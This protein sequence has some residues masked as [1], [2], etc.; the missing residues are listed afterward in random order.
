MEKVK[1]LTIN[2]EWQCHN[3]HSLNH[4][5]K[6]TYEKPKKVYC[7]YCNK[8]YLVEGNN[9]MIIKEKIDKIYSMVSVIYGMVFGAIT[10]EIIWFIFRIFKE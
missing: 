6:C 2:L 9:E 7:S 3:C 10:V 4:T 5:N 1:L 8:E